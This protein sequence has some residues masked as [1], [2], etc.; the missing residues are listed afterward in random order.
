M[1][2]IEIKKNISKC[3][4]I[5]TVIVNEDLLQDGM[6]SCT[7]YNTLHDISISFTEDCDEVLDDKIAEFAVHLI[8]DAE[9]WRRVI[10]EYHKMSTKNQISKERALEMVVV[11]VKEML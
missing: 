7:V 10:F 6:V 5:V 9:F 3:N 11:I 8:S 1:D 2:G 4:S